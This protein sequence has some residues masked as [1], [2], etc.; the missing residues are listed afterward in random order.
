MIWKNRAAVSNFPVSGQLCKAPKYQVSVRF[1]QN[2]KGVRNQVYYINGWSISF[3]CILFKKRWF[4][5]KT[6]KLETVQFPTRFFTALQ[7]E[8]PDDLTVISRTCSINPFYRL[9]EK[10]SSGIS[11][12]Q[13]GAVLFQTSFFKSRK[14][15]VSV[16]IKQN[17]Q[18]LP[19]QM[20]SID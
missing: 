6:Y 4:F 13:F 12:Q 2:F 18:R 8:V 19:S 5:K 17:F 9:S 14:N 10:K 16:P 1:I 15:P 7:N 20:F 3:L 11:A